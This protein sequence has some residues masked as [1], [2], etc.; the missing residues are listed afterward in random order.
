[1]IPGMTAYTHM[2]TNQEIVQMHT[3]LC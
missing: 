2:L 3:W 1:V